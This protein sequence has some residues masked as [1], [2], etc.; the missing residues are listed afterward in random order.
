[1]AIILVG[2]GSVAERLIGTM[3]SRGHSVVLVTSDARNAEEFSFEF[4]G[5]MVIGG[6]ARDPI[7]LKQA[8]AADAAFVVAAS[9]DDAYNLSVCLLAREAFHVPAV[10]GLAGHPQN[11]RIFRALDIPCI[12]C[13]EIIA[14]SVLETLEPRASVV[15]G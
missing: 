9:D 3:E 1:M 5:A 6:D 12:S 10:I 4:P 14:D 11:V 2:G 15:T 13:S 7:V 8:G